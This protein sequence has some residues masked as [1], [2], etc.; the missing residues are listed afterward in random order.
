[1]DRIAPPRPRGDR[2]LSRRRRGRTA[3]PGTGRRRNA[4]IVLVVLAAL[5]LAACKPLPPVDEGP[6]PPS[7]YDPGEVITAEPT[8]FTLDPVFN[9]PTPLV[10]AQRLYYRTTSATGEAIGV[11]GTVLVPEVPWSGPG[12]RP[13]VTYAVGT[14]GVGD[15]CA[16]SSTLANGTD[17]E[18]LFITALLLKGWAVAVTDY[19]GLGTDGLH[20]YM[21]GRSQGHAVLDMARAAQDVA[22]GGVDAASPVGIWGYSQG[23]ASAGWAAQLEDTY[24]PELDVVGVVAGGVPA[25]LGAVADFVDGGPFVAFALLA[26]LGYD[27]AYPELSLESYLNADGLQLQAD[28]EDVCLVSLDGISTFLGT[29][30]RTIDSYTTANPLATPAWQGRLGENRLGADAPAV[31]VYQYH[32]VFDEIVPFDQAGDLRDAWCAQGVQLTWKQYWLAEHALG[33]V[34]GAPSG[35]AYLADRFA[36]VPAGTTC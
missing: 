20:T 21:V 8:T 18:G 34:E 17:Y 15:A 16:P 30:F 35:V 14:R 5:V 28:S 22:G 9:T 29:A 6:Q 11:S 31:P 7:A 26:A 4:A 1:M 3:A 13:L 24:A 10:D 32:A 27:A 2:D 33:L 23:G 19:E 12:S 36:G 25:D